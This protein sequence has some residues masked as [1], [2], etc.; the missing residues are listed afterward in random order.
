MT[1]AYVGIGSNLGDR[2]AYLDAAIDGLSGLGRVVSGSPVYETDSVGGTDQG[3]YLNAVVALD[4]DLAPADLLD[5]LLAIERAQGRVRDVRW[6]PRTL[7]LDILLYDGATID[8]P[9]LTVPHPEIRNRRFVLVPLTDIDSTLCDAIGPYAAALPSVAD[10]PITRRTGPLH[11]TEGRWLV[12]LEEAIALTRD[13]DGWVFDSHPDW[14]NSMGQMFGAYVSAVSLFATRDIAGS[15]FP[16]SL[17]HRFLHG[18]PVGTG[19]TVHVHV[20]RRSDRS[21]DATVS[22]A[23][24]GK[25]AGHTTITV[26]AELP[27]V[28]SCP[29]APDVGGIETAVPIGRLVKHLGVSIGA[30]ALNWGPL[31]NWSVPDL[32][33]GT[34]SVVRIWSPNVA[35]GS[36]DPYLTAASMLMPIDATVWPATMLDMG[37]LPAGPLIPTP[38]TEFTIRFARPD[39][40]DLYHLAEAVIDH[41][42]RSSV[43]GTV[44]L[45]GTDGGYRAIG[46]SQ[47]LVRRPNPFLRN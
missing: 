6:G 9:R 29:V 37:L 3:A 20:D 12:G 18:I 21:V 38:T 11:A 30:S 24:D 31:E 41:R 35:V 15:M 26:V 40:D 32:A 13:G 2:H 4:T 17:T 1:L 28:T 7:D 16:V 25:S 36:R 19:G 5:A 47:N 44:R 14:A 43:A 8:L 46:Y 42:T 34:S 33:D 39:T 23:V 22:L 10:Q 27:E 45:W